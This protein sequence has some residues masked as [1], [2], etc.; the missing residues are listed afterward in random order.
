[1]EKVQQ[2][3]DK[4][5]ERMAAHDHADYEGLA[6]LTEELRSLEEELASLEERW[7]GLSELLG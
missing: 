7:L 3:V 6:R 1:M 5:H 2:S 4:L